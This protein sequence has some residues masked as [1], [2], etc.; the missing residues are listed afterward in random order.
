MIGL[1]QWVSI[2]LLGNCS[3]GCPN[4]AYCW[5]NLARAWDWQGCCSTRTVHGLS[6]SHGTVYCIVHGWCDHRYWHTLCYIVRGASQS[7]HIVHGCSCVVG[8]WPDHGPWDTVVVIV[9]LTRDLQWYSASNPLLDWSSCENPISSRLSANEKLLMNVLS[10]SASSLASFLD[11]HLAFLW[12]EGPNWVPGEP[13]SALWLPWLLLLG[14]G[15]ILPS[16]SVFL[17]TWF[18][19]Q[20]GY[21]ETMRYSTLSH[22]AYGQEMKK[23]I[24]YERHTV[25]YLSQMWQYVV[26]VL[27]Y[28]QGIGDSGGWGIHIK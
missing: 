17:V 25:P 16:S 13:S 26:K 1:L 8:S 10:S 5:Y 21:V 23:Y 12:Q 4:F 22:T 14:E 27:M 9:V 3:F 19:T 7:C 15:E 18:R 20:P 11:R 24:H 28:A 2:C 6:Q